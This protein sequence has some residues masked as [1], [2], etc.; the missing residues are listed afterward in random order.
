MWPFK[1]EEQRAAS[2]PLAIK[3]LDEFGNTSPA[4]VANIF[5]VTSFISKQLA[6]Y[7]FEAPEQLEQLLNTGTEQANFSALWSSVYLS[8]LNTGNAYLL[9]DWDKNGKLNSF[10]PVLAAPNIYTD[11][12]SQPYVKS[13][14][15]GGT[16]YPTY[17]VAHF[18]INSLNGLLG[19]SPITVCRES[20]EGIRKVE[21]FSNEI[22]NFIKRPAGI[23]K[24]TNS[25]K[26]ENTIDRFRESL[27]KTPNGKSLVLE[28]GIEYQPLSMSAV[29]S[30]YVEQ[31]K[32]SVEAACR[33]FALDPL[34]ISHAGTNSQSYNSA[35]SARESLYN[36]TLKPYLEAVTAELNLKLITPAQRITGA[37]VEVNQNELL[38]L[39][40]KDRVEVYK[41]LVDMGAITPE[42]VAEKEGFRNA[43][44]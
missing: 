1:K 26:D 33:L 32:F 37:K 8:L 21:A 31:A 25:F 19:R 34:F 13:F 4:S 7:K 5:A 3:N 30:D 16:T 40:V 6:N 20:V 22:F 36:N 15:V 9:L 14:T 35:V 41:S 27:A 39:G 44:S 12:N 24:F 18:R 23:F 10:K 11:T 17:R 43:H 28:N 29:D 42:Q 2:A 38:S